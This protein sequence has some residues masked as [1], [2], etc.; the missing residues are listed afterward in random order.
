ME[1]VSGPGGEQIMQGKR[2]PIIE[3]VIDKSKLSSFDGSVFFRLDPDSAHLEECGDAEQ[4][5]FRRLAMESQGGRAN[6]TDNSN[7]H[8]R[9]L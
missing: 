7:F 1:P 4:L 9:A 6:I 2:K 8:Q 3:V 5:H